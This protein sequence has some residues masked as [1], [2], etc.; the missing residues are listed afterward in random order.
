MENCF[1]PSFLRSR[2]FWRLWLCMLG[3]FWKQT[4]VSLTQGL[5]RNPGNSS[6]LIKSKCGMDHVKVEFTPELR[7]L[8]SDLH[9]HMVYNILPAYST[10]NSIPLILKYSKFWAQSQ[11]ISPKRAHNLF[12][13]KVNMKLLMRCIY[14]ST[15]FFQS[16]VWKL[17]CTTHRN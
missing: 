13:E 16:L 11:W 12:L 5:H 10:Q 14:D 7:A 1:I 2:S 8:H 4:E 17:S 6:S 3:S 9:I 15:L